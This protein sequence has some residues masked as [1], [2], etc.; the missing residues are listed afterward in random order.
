VIYK[1][2]TPRGFVVHEFA[3]IETAKA[4]VSAFLSWSGTKYRIVKARQTVTNPVNLD[5]L[6]NAIREGAN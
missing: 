6:S 4:Y 1:V 2:E 3:N 5:M